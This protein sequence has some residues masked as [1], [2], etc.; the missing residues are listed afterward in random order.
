MTQVYLYRAFEDETISDMLSPGFFDAA[1]GIIRQDDLLLLYSPNETTAKYVYARVSNV[2]RDGVEIN[3]IGIDA[4]SIFVNTTGFSKL[5]GGNLQEIIAQI[6]NYLD[7]ILG[8]IPSDAT[9]I[10]KLI[11][12]NTLETRAVLKDSNVPQE[13]QSGLKTPEVEITNALV[14]KGTAEFEI[15]PLTDDLTTYQGATPDS[16]MRKAQIEEV[17]QDIKT[18]SLT[19]KGYVS[20]TE[21]SS[22]TYK[23]N[24]HDLWLNSATMPT[25]FP[26]PQASIK[27]WDGTAWVAYNHDYTP[28]NFDFFRNIND[29]E[30]YYWFAGEWVVMSTDMSTTYFQLNP[31]TGKWEIKSNV[32]LPG[33]PTT[34]TP[35]LDDES[36]KIPTTKWVKEAINSFSITPKQ[37]V[38][39][40][41]V[42]YVLPTKD[43]IQTDFNPSTRPGGSKTALRF[44][45]GTVLKTPTG[46]IFEVG[47]TDSVIEISTIVQGTA[48]AAG[49]KVY[50]Y[51]VSNGDGTASPVVSKSATYSGYMIGGFAMLCPLRGGSFTNLPASH[52]YYS[53]SNS[54]NQ[55]MHTSVWHLKNAYD[56]N[57]GVCVYN[58]EKRLWVQAYIP[59]L[60]DSA[61]TWQS[62]SYSTSNGGGTRYTDPTLQLRSVYNVAPSNN[63]TFGEQS[64]WLKMAGGRYIF[65]DEFTS[66]AE[67]SNEQTNVNGSNQKNAV[68][69]WYDTANRPMIS[70]FGAWEMNG[71][72][73]QDIAINAAG[74]SGWSNQGLN[75]GQTYGGQRLRAGAAWSNGAS[76]GSLSRAAASAGVE[77]YADIAAR[78]ASPCYEII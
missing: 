48:L 53:Y 56:Q 11:S 63:M 60:Y 75:K 61:G 32:N 39:I 23:F 44:M 7:D 17:V 52:P 45:A 77:R 25:S 70:N 3:Q 15:A 57:L 38:S 29:N 37:A 73:W 6:D 71:F 16:L 74:G 68:G 9:P 62:G 76:S 1:L 4:A 22:A 2:D 27:E 55:I 5:T 59:S 47:D 51:L 34:T 18:S 64:Q 58:S 49:D 8:V 35:S 12:V 43:F 41:I 78:G 46:D 36:T 69:G 14:A 65:D 54:G 42:N 31:T 28:D 33:A 72:Y 66:T 13:M 20:T 10:N 30:G 24:K 21:P 26:V 19:F 50:I 67:G 40:G